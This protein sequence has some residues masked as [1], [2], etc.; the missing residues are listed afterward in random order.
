MNKYTNHL[1][2]QMNKKNFH[3]LVNKNT[4]IYGTLKLGS[5]SHSHPHGYYESYAQHKSL[6]LLL[7]I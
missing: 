6:K 3:M 2:F 7:K 5:I 1:Y 4:Q